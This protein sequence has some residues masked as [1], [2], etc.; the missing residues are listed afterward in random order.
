MGQHHHGREIS[1][2]SLNQQ[3]L[4]AYDPQKIKKAVSHM[5]N[6]ADHYANWERRLG[7]SGGV[8]LVLGSKGAEGS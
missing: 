1:V 3:A 7:V 8:A 2:A 4:P 5:V 6:A